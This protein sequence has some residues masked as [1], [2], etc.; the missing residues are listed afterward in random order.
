MT[1]E[2]QIET[3]A[4]IIDEYFEV[5]TTT[6]KQIAESL[7]EAGYRKIPEGAVVLTQKDLKEYAKD[8]LIGEIAGLDILNG[9]FAKVERVSEETRKETAK[10]LYN[11]AKDCVEIAYFENKINIKARDYIYK[12]LSLMISDF[13]VEIKK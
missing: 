13:G 10:R 2:Q 7:Y 4:K 9:A 5:Y 6:P 3:M 12:L 1:K 11:K 8:C